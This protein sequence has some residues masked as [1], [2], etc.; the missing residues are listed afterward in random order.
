MKPGII[1]PYEKKTVSVQEIPEINTIRISKDA[2]YKMN[3]YASI[4][5]EISGYPKE[6]VG[7]ILNYKNKNDNIARDIHL[8]R[9]QEVTGS[10]GWRGNRL[11]DSK[12]IDERGMY[13]IG[14]W[15]SHGSNGVFHSSFDNS[16]LKEMFPWIKKQEGCWR[17]T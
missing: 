1:N 14:L 15:H 16:V 11:D 3:L 5:S 12:E 2:F 17:K 6:C 8:E 4:V 9:G 7:T 10:N 13:V